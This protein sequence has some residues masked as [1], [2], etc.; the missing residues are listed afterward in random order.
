MATR[1]VTQ[2]APNNSTGQQQVTLD[3]AQETAILTYAGKAHE[4]LLNQFSLRSFLQEVD[5]N[6]MRENDI[7][8]DQQ[9]AR[10]ANRA[11][12]SSK[13]QNVTVP[14]IMPQVEAALGYMTNVYL[15][16][17]PIFGVSSDPATEDSALQMETIIAENAVTAGWIRQLLMFFRDGLKYNLHGVECEWQ[18]RT[19]YTVETDAAFP[20]SA[21]PKQTL[22]TGNALRRMDL[23]NTFFDPRVHAAEIHEKGEYAGYIEI[24][25]RV[26]LKDYINKL[27]GKIPIA[28]VLRAFKSGSA[29]GEMS[30]SAPFAYYQPLI[31]PA[32]L[33]SKNSGN[34]F[35]WMAWVT[36]SGINKNGIEYKNAYE[37]MKLYARIIPSDFGL[38]VS[39]S[40]TPQV[41]KFIII[42]GQVILYAER[43]PNV[44]NWI[45]I[46]FGQ[47]LEDG[48]DY[49]TKSFAANVQDM[50]AVATGFLNGYI[51]AKRRLVADRLLYDPLRVA[52]K[53]INSD[54]PTAKIPVRPGAYGKPVSE[55]VYQFPF[56]DEQT[57]TLL[58]GVETVTRYAN[59][60]NGQN[61]AQQGQFVKGNKT[62]HE[63]EDIMGHGNSKNQTMAMM[64]EAQ[65]F[66]PLKQCILLN[67]LQF[68]PD[69]VL[70]N[71]DKKQNV[72]IN[73]T[74]L[75]KA[76]VHFKVSD[77][78]VPTDK[79]MAGDEF[80]T[81]LQVIGTSPAIAQGYNVA[82][83]FTYVM[84]M[85]GA[86][87]SP[88]EKPQL[89]VMYEQQLAAW[90]QAA[91]EAAKQGVE[92]KTPMPQIPP[93]L[94][95]QLGN[96]PAQPQQSSSS[97]ALEA[98]QG[99][100]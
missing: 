8:E 82:P 21:K 49:Q 25:S 94:Q 6:Y 18:Q 29:G 72:T 27:F 75:R 97:S 22:W 96:G 39:E 60:I 76:A 3:S 14:V 83:M 62:K 17:Y 32:P 91:A 61:P 71:R 51:A 68:Q 48:L 56:H 95:Q 11:G 37:V 4:L 74:D 44:H 28:T 55:A 1:S 40:N 38:R 46:F 54:S 20:N 77:G 85:R 50:Q 98:T 79:Q 45:P 43:Q 36:A 69:G 5:R 64:T 73:T 57:Q 70:F 19:V 59:L 33:M 58:Q 41:W 87:L 47:P 89:Q 35:D 13:L 52:A 92:F 99:N 67:I 26:Q 66:T 100:A 80:Q 42:N 24:M 30:A 84:K 63:Y 2:T 81:A 7:T 53:D 16:G 65:V 34:N 78:L 15:T 86:D 10:L 9:K 90:Q 93:Q 88:F 23:Y 12:N 31:N